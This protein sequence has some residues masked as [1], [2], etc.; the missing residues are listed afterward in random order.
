MLPM[1]ERTRWPASRL[2]RSLLTT[3]EGA[4]RAAAVVLP[5]LTPWPVA[6][7]VNTLHEPAL[8]TATRRALGDIGNLFNNRC[9]VGGQAKPAGAKKDKPSVPA[10]KAQACALLT[11][12]LLA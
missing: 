11:A 10:E 6:M 12:C 1:P 2:L 7:A 8:R 3:R 9:N 4:E 5:D